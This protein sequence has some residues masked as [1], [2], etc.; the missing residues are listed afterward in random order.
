MA[1][2]DVG[3]KANHQAITAQH[4]PTTTNR[5]SRWPNP[6]PAGCGPEA[7]VCRWLPGRTNKELPAACLTK[8]EYIYRSLVCRIRLKHRPGL[9]PS[10]LDA[11]CRN[12]AYRPGDRLVP[13]WCSNGRAADSSCCM[14]RRKDRLESR[15]GAVC[16]RLS[17][18]PDNPSVFR[19]PHQL[20]CNRKQ[21]T[22]GIDRADC[23][24]RGRH[25]DSRSDGRPNRGP[26]CLRWTGWEG[27]VQHLNN[28]QSA[29]KRRNS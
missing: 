13:R 15:R 20:R 23:R 28:R 27:N 2:F 24:I 6:L 22:R 17:D 25:F 18:I 10:N 21:A 9:A 19:R 11:H 4:H 7:G 26:G 29:N 3:R 5:D 16:P 14:A 1:A 12:G 8:L